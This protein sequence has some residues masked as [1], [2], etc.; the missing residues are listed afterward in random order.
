MKELFYK[1]NCKIKWIYCRKAFN[2]LNEQVYLGNIEIER[3]TKCFCGSQS[4]EQLS[5]FD[6]YG[7]PFGTQICL[8]CGLISQSIKFA[9]K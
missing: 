5:R 1:L 4:F 9:E 2:E 8:D 3:V 6:R 7:L